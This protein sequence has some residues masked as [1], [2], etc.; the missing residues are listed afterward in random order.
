MSSPTENAIL[1]TGVVPP[2]VLP[3]L[4]YDVRRYT[5]SNTLDD[6]FSVTANV[7]EELPPLA[8]TPHGTPGLFNGTWVGF[9]V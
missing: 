4:I 5:D 8:Y 2:H 6:P 1:P 9:P 7:F 3:S